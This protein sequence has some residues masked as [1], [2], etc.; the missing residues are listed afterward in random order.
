MWEKEYNGHR[1]DNTHTNTKTF[2][3]FAFSTR[4]KLK[5]SEHESQCQRRCSSSNGIEVSARLIFPNARIMNHEQR[6]LHRHDFRTNRF[7]TVPLSWFNGGYI[8]WNQLTADH[9]QFYRTNFVTIFIPL[10]CFID[11]NLK[12]ERTSIHSIK[13]LTLRSQNNDECYD[14]VI[15]SD[16]F[17]CGLGTVLGTGIM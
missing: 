4:W 5:C 16:I 10:F 14:L 8:E 15:E 11:I 9:V 1:W 2:T 6:L 13:T 12:F 17:L 3:K 7:S